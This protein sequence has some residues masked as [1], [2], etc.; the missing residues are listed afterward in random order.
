MVRAIPFMLVGAVLGGVAMWSVCGQAAPATLPPGP[1]PSPLACDAEEVRRLRERVTQLED[2]QQ[3]VALGHS[4]RPAESSGESAGE[5][6]SIKPS[7]AANDASSWRISAIEKFVPLSPEQKDRLKEKYTREST[8]KE[9]GEE[10]ETESL[11]DILGAENATYYREQV[12]AAFTRVQREEIERESV[13]L[14]RKLGLSADQESSMRQIFERIESEVG[15][16][17]GE[18]HS[19]GSPEDRV[20]A[21]IAENRRRSELRNAELARVLTPEQRRTYA[22]LEAESSASDI[23][24]FHDPGSG[25]ETGEAKNEGR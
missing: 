3:Q 11:D 22:Q 19:G 17:S 25:Q 12:Q 7:S 4:T 6:H 5:S 23:E 15:Q 16:L 8:A 14:S 24:V 13:W 10:V 2:A 1:P 21:L 18:G 20:R 9:D